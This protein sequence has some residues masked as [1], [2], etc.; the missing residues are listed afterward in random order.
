MPLRNAHRP[1]YV[2]KCFALVEVEMLAGKVGGENGYRAGVKTWVPLALPQGTAPQIRA[3]F[4]L[5]NGKVDEEQIRGWFNESPLAL[6]S[7]LKR[8]GGVY[9]LKTPR[10]R[11]TIAKAVGKKGGGFR[12]QRKHASKFRKSHR[13]KNVRGR[14]KTPHPK[15]RNRR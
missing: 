15:K 3:E 1:D 11:R 2:Y 12:K 6:K 10:A 7:V 4:F 14:N 5:A 8:V 13:P 9:L